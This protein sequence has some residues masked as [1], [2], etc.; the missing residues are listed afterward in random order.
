L[1]SRSGRDDVEG[2]VDRPK[3]SPGGGVAA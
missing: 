2:A 3:R 1:R